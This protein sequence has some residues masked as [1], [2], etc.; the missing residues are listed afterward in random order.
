MHALAQNIF[1][2]N[3]KKLII[4]IIII[5]EQAITN[6]NEQ[7][8]LHAVSCTQQGRQRE[9]NVKTL[10]SPLSA[11]FWRHCMLRG[12]TPSSA[13]TPER[14]KENVNLNYYLSFP[15]A[16]IEP[17]TSYTYSHILSPYATTGLKT[18]DKI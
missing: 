7:N 11:E 18:G 8:Q 2:I 3:F 16:E 13:S 12:G 5:K 9:P 1:I 17:T 10:R 14:R 6:I 4:L 15:R